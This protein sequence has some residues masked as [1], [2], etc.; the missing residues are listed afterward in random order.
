VYS[1]GHAQGRTTIDGPALVEL[2]RSVLCVRPGQSVQ[3]SADD[4]L[5]ITLPAAD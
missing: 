2:R 5:K 1:L 3:M 4:V